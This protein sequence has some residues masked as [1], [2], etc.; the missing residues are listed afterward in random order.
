MRRPCNY[1]RCRIEHSHAKTPWRGAYEV[2]LGE[3]IAVSADLPPA[4]RALGRWSEAFCM[5][6]QRTGG[7]AELSA[8]VFE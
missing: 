6:F 7:T 5:I 4:P 3:F 8:T 2:R 1:G